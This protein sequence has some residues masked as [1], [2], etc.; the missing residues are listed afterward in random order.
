[1]MKVVI[2]FFIFFSLFQDLMLRLK[3]L[4]VFLSCKHHLFFS[5]QIQFSL[6]I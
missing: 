5:Q 3:D 1:M 6:V 4:K 2:I